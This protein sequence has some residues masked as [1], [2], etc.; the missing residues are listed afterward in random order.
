MKWKEI[1]AAPCT[2][3]PEGKKDAVRAQL[4][5]NYLILDVWEDGS[6]KCRHAMHRITGEPGTLYPDGKRTAENLDGAFGGTV[7]YWGIPLWD[8]GLFIPEEDAGLIRKNTEKTY[9]NGVLARVEIMEEEYVRERHQKAA[10]ARIDRL[11]RL[12][13]MCPFPG[14]AVSDWI[15]QTAGSGQYAFYDKKADTWH[16]TACNADFAEQQTG[17]RKIRQHD[18]TVCPL[19]GSSLTAEKRKKTVT[20]HVPMYMIHDADERRGVLRFF[21][22]TFTWSD[23][24]R[25]CFDERI[26]IMLQRDMKLPCKI[27]YSDNWSGWSEGNRANRRFKSGYLYPDEKAIREGLAGTE[28]RIWEKVLPY[29]AAAG[30][31]ADYNG[32][33]CESNPYWTGIAEYLAKGRFYRLLDEETQRITAWG[34]YIGRTVNISGNGI[35][36][37][38]KLS[39]GQLINRLRQENGGRLMLGW[40]QWSESHGSRITAECMSWLHEADLTAEGYEASPAADYLTPQQLMNYII[41]QKKESYPK[42]GYPAVLRQYEDYLKMAAQLG[43]NMDDEMVYRPRELKRRHDGAVEEHNAR[44]EEM[45]RKRDAEAARLEAERMRQKYPGY[46]DILEEVSRKYEYASGDYLI[47]VPKDFAEITAEGMA[48]HHCVGHTERYFDRIVSRETYICFLR[49]LS[50]PDEPFYTIEVEPGGTIRQ[51][52]GAYDEEPGIEEIK[53]FLREWQKVIRSRMSKHDHEYARQSA[54]LRQKNIEE[55]REKNNIRV[56]DGLMEDLMEV[57]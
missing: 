4:S 52:R 22:V 36:E 33:L 10:D 25:I 32:L 40:L 5:E 49:R 46:E 28:Y 45:R 47:R 27:Y 19:C 17:I 50:S 51:H 3:C 54:V 55:L 37:V 39:D 11:N 8:E 1:L 34:G 13:G 21:D 41:R 24:R 2:E 14:K 38:L 12:M 7:R 56:L 43:K 57:I 9:G 6:Y 35:G 44:R 29:L 42:L 31:K 26:R 30:I 18:T 16:C 15:T 20:R 23:E 48:L 53:P